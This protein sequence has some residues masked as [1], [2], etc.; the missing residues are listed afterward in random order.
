MTVCLRSELLSRHGFR[1]GFSL[2]AGGVSQGAFESM[3]LGRGL[4]DAPDH[5]AENHR[6]LASI[7]GYAPERLYEVTQVHGAHVEHVAIQVSASEF[8]SRE[9]DAL[10][11]SEPDYAVGVR[12]ADCVAV[13]LADPQSGQVAAAHAGWRGVVQQVVPRAVAALCASAC[14][15]P[16]RLLAAVLPHIG[17]SAFEVGPDV[18]AQI[19]ASVPSGASPIVP[20]PK[21]RVSLQRCIEG[22]LRAAGLRAERIDVVPGCTYSDPARF[23][24][25][26][27]DGA[28]TGRHL[29]VILAGC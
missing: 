27:R 5:V 15:D 2:R 3:N 24:S 22:Q 18:A 14:A 20:G 8:L 9:A 7:I 29:A 12:T 1:H 6:R 25:F 11:L 10:L 19:A 4:G 13:L 16:A 17:E 21:P 26:R 23:F 28:Q